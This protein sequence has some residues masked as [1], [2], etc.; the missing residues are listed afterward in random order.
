M[1]D[2]KRI[3]HL[4]SVLVIARVSERLG[5]KMPHMHFTKQEGQPHNEKWADNIH[6][7]SLLLGNYISDNCPFFSTG[8]L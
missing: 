1:G 2:K 7:R 4:C 6:S 8:L 5:C 3:E